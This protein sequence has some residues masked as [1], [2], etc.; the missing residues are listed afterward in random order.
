[1]FTTNSLNKEESILKSYNLRCFSYF[2][3]VLR[4]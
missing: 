1:M 2:Y 4:Y 3:G